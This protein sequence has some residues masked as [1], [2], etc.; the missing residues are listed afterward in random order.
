MLM[1]ASK[2][3]ELPAVYSTVQS[4]QPVPE[5]SVPTGE[6]WAKVRTQVGLRLPLRF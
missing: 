4:Q 2:L 1:D 5:Q 3:C 6:I